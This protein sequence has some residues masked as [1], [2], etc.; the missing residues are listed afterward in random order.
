MSV[1]YRGNKAVQYE[2]GIRVPAFLWHKS[3]EGGGRVDDQLLTVMDIM[4]TILDLTGTVAPGARFEGREVM[5]IRGRSFAAVA[6]DAGAV[7][8]PDD[9]DIALA[10]AGRNVMFRGPF[11]LVRELER[12]WELFNLVADP[13]ETKDLSSAMPDL[14]QDMISAFE[15]FALERNYLDRVPAPGTGP[16]P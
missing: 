5:P 12:D 7:V 14:R 8:H 2:G 9:E 4:P 13:S 3:I 11:K 15:A 16:D 1:A 10:S 6:N